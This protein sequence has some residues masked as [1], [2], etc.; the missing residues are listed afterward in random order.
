VR[1]REKCSCGAEIEVDA[2]GAQQVVKDWREEHKHQIR[3]Y[4]YTYGATI[5]PA[6]ATNGVAQP[7][8]GGI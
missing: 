3:S 8:S 7:Q 5:S 4:P 6:W 1:I 2:A